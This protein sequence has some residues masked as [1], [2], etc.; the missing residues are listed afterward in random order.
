MERSAQS[1]LTWEPCSLLHCTAWN[2]FHVTDEGEKQKYNLRAWRSTR[3]PGESW[4][5]KVP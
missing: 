1:L 2:I 5:S 4:G 3:T